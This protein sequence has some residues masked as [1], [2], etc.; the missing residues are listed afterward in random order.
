MRPLGRPVN[1]FTHHTTYVTEQVVQPAPPVQIDPCAFSETQAW[2]A[3]AQGNVHVAIE[4]FA[5]LARGDAYDALMHVGYAIANAE[6]GADESAIAVMR[7]AVQID[8][9]SLLQVPADEQLDERI[10]SLLDRFGQQAVDG[11]RPGDALFMVAALRTALHDDA[12]AYFAVTEA[13]R[14]GSNDVAALR[15]QAMLSELLQAQMV[16]AG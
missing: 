5:C 10:L 15:L 2:E 7:H 8:A 11:V 9:E 4:A 13:I 1:V 6:L 14:H 16:P 3:L 12:G